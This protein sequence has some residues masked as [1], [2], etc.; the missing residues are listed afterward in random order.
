MSK[1]WEKVR[2]R[3]IASCLYNGGGG[4]FIVVLAT[5]PQEE[6]KRI[7]WATGLCNHVSLAEECGLRLEDF[8]E[9]VRLEVVGGGEVRGDLKTFTFYVWGESPEYGREP[10]RE[11]T[12]EEFDN[13]FLNWKAVGTPPSEGVFKY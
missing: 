10:E 5:T 4:K 3:I 11:K 8:A 1:A 6:T 12:V 13:Y 2:S 7:V 9:D